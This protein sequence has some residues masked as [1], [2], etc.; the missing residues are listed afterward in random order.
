M[1]RLEVPEALALGLILK[2]KD[3]QNLFPSLQVLT[4][5]E[6]PRVGG[7]L[8]YL[9]T[10]SLRQLTFNLNPRRDILPGEVDRILTQLAVGAPAIQG[11]VIEQADPIGSFPAEAMLRHASIRK[12][13]FSENITLSLLQLRTLFSMPRLESLVSTIQS[14][15]KTEPPQ[16]L[17]APTLKTLKCTGS[18]EALSMLCSHLAAPLL[19][20]LEVICDER[21]STYSD[22]LRGHRDLVRSI[23]GSSLAGHLHSLHYG[24]NEA[25]SRSLYR[26]FLEEDWAAL[27]T[28]RTPASAH[29]LSDIISPLFPK[30][31]S[32]HV[33]AF[34]LERLTV[35]IWWPAEV[36][37]ADMA[38][39][40]GGFGSTLRSNEFSLY[41]TTPD[42]EDHG[43]ACRVR[44][45]VEYA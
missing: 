3:E 44:L 1:A 41:L 10:P 32:P 6:S 18:C 26:G 2:W 5:M 25:L 37:D 12:L 36:R 13:R 31:P 45:E 15:L 20:R 40:R 22:C 29:P 11:M 35:D 28:S 4:W 34:S 39:I 17:Y 9:G 30:T 8:P 24:H 27:D 42:D 38:R 23:A 14:E 21:R 43:R 33:R 7:L 16:A 19:A